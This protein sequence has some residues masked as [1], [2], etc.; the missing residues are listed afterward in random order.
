MAAPLFDISARE[1][2]RARAVRRSPAPFLAERIVEDFRER[3]LPVRRE[4]GFALVTGCPPGL[5][6]ELGGVA[7]RIS[8]STSI[9]GLADHDEGSIDLLLVVGELDLHDELPLLLRIAHSRLS[10]E[11][12]LIGALPGANSLPSLRAALHAADSASG[13]FAPHTHPRI[14]PGALAA[15]LGDAGFAEPVV[16]IDRV[17]L[18]YPSLLRLVGDLRDHGAT[19]CLTARPRAGLGRAAL[20]AAEHNFAQAQGEER[21]ELL[22]YAGWA[23]APKRNA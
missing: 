10:R 3:L 2:H 13:R 23:S 9:S 14:E 1:Q 21:I 17:K 4:F 7:K 22:H 8:F 6:S 5:H 16:D 18:R 15:L 12:L 20:A 11:G 19:N